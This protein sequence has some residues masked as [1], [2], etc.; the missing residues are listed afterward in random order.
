MEGSC[1]YINKQSRTAKRGGP[2]AWGLGEVLATPHRKN[3]SCYESFTQKAPDLDVRGMDWIELAQYRN[4]W[5]ILV[6]AVMNLRV[7]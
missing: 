1:E 7:P 2:P 3:V 6:N 5:R 4:R